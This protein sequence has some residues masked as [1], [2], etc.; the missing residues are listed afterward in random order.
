MP[1]ELT[2]EQKLI[3]NIAR[4]FAVTELRPRAQQIDED[5]EF[6]MDLVYRATE[7]GFRGAG[8]PEEYG[9]NGGGLTEQCLIIEELCKESAL[10]A[11]IGPS[12]LATGIISSNNQ[13]L[14]EKYAIPFID[15]KILMAMG[16]T[17][18]QAGSDAS[19]IQTR[20]V[21][22]GDAWILNGNKSFITGSSWADAFYI[23]ARTKDEQTGEEGIS[24]FITDK[25]MP[26]FQEGA[27]CHKYWWR[28]SGTGE[29]YLKN[30]RVPEGSMI[31]T[32]NKGL[33]VTFSMLDQGRLICAVAALG[34]AEGALE[35]AIDY[36][37]QRIQFGKTI[38][39][40]QAIQ[41]MLA[42]MKLDIEAAKALIYNAAALKDAGKRITMESAYAKL[43]ST[44][45]SKRVCDNAIQIC[46]GMGLDKHFGIDRYYRDAR[47]LSI[48]EGT[49]QIQR[50]IISRE[51]LR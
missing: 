12:I 40:F 44:E 20:A 3:K 21:K 16:W 50:H 25:S 29:I 23:S 35:K 34:L 48:A 2:E 51:L 26:G 15:G 8:Y 36:S 39:Q 11:L 22:E 1:L 43:F 10:G 14:I 42:D 28:G 32:L 46:G 18:P 6:P 47:A 19:N 13:A 24:V 37:K 41:H 7:L 5:D 49:S 17:E 33:H 45:A 38:S 4:E 9:G 30:C 31:G 27:V